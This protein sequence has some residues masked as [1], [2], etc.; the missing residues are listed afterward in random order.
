MGR[1][2]QRVRGRADGKIVS[3]AVRTSLEAVLQPKG[4]RPKKKKR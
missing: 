3:E 1:V 2:M 4:E